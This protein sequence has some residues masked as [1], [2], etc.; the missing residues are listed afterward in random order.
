MK[1]IFL[2]IFIA[3]S[4]VHLY[5]TYIDNK[6]IRGVTKGFILLSLFSFYIA[7][8]PEVNGIIA[9]AL[10]FSFLG[11]VLLQIKK[12]FVLG[13]ISFGFAHICF[14]VA[15]SRNVDF[16]ALPFWVYLIVAAVYIPPII[17][18]LRRTR[19]YASKVFACA[20]AVYLLALSSTGAFAL[21]QLC[22]APSAATA[23]VY[24]GS[25]FFLV[26]DLMLLQLRLIPGVKIWRKHFSVMVT[27]ILAEFLIVYGTML[28]K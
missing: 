10:V 16:S 17:W 7:A 24:V 14:A 27:Y 4:L 23:V 20:V 15:F 19:N 9:A 28:L 25:L 5:G 8:A 2:A 13:G 12:F 1:Y 18:M 22:S 3:F 6:T 11:D 21:F 26:S